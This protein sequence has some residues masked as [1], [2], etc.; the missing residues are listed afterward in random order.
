VE[1]KNAAE[2]P[3]HVSRFHAMQVQKN[4]SLKSENVE[5]VI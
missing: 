3:L 2:F 5:V 1:I 4:V